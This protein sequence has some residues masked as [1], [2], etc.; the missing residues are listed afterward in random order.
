MI[1][2]KG[3]RGKVTAA[4]IIVTVKEGIRLNPE[5]SLRMNDCLSVKETS[6]SKTSLYCIQPTLGCYQIMTSKGAVFMERRRLIGGFKN[7]NSYMGGCAKDTDEQK[8][9]AFV[10]IIIYLMYLDG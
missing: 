9:H 6:K 3:K 4:M 8:S 7:Q 10:E 5:L 2:C 1:N